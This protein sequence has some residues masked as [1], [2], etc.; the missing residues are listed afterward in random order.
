[1]ST[2][3]T[4][5]ASIPLPEDFQPK[6]NEEFDY[7]DPYILAW[8]KENKNLIQAELNFFEKAKLEDKTGLITQV[9]FHHYE[10]AFKNKPFFYAVYRVSYQIL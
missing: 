8:A 7:K 6:E 2:I 3:R 1:M 4:S 10:E 9:E 5:T